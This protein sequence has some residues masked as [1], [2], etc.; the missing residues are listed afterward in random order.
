MTPS[1]IDRK[2]LKADMTALLADA[3]VSHKAMAALYLGLLLVL[4]LLAYAG[5]SST[6]ILSTFLSILT[7][8]VSMVLAGGFTLYC[9]AIRRGERA[10]FFTLF[11]GFSMAGKL[12]L[13]TLLQSIVI[14]LWSMLFFIPGIVAAYRYRFALYN[15]YENPQI[16]ALEAMRMSK[17]QTFGYKMQLFRM[18]MSYLGWF[19]LSALPLLVE[20]Y[21]YNMEA[22][23]YMLSG[24]A[25]PET[26]AVYAFLPDWG[27]LIL[28]G[29]WQ[30]AVSTFYMAHMQCV[31][32]GYFEAAKASSGVSA[33]RPE[34]PSPDAF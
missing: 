6:A 34:A 4:D 20:M 14:A 26:F 27:W 3:Q 13:L 30:L 23:Q 12:I 15:L 17:Q 33:V 18:D 5:G 22:T 2:R 31:E 25:L 10:E 32:L 21:W 9:M 19:L 29:L 24:A 7:G 8:L 11:D 28:T 1:L 16:S